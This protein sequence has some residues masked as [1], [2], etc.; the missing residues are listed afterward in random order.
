M[1]EYSTNLLL[2]AA[3]YLALC[4]AA[5]LYISGQVGRDGMEGLLLGLFFG[6]AGLIVAACLP[7]PAARAVARAAAGPETIAFG[8]DD[9]DAEEDGAVRGRLAELERSARRPARPAPP[10]VPAPR[11]RRL[12]GEVEE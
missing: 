2:A 7:R 12:L 4:G 1:T 11:S 6:P 5:G 9:D 3:I 10:P 8:D